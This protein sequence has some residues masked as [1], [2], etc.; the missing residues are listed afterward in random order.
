MK[1]KNITQ[2]IQRFNISLMRLF[3]LFGFVALTISCEM[4]DDIPPPSAYVA[5]EPVEGCVQ[6][7]GV[8]ELSEG[9]DFECLYPEFGTFGGTDAGTITV[10]PADNPFKE[11]INTS[12]KVIMVTQTAGV[13]GWAGIFFDVANKIDFSEEQTIKIKV[14]S[15]AAGQTI[16]LKLEDSADSSLSKEVSTTTT[17]AEGMGRAFIYIL[18][19]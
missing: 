2:I 7:E 19:R 9:I 11:G 13:E 16:L 14:Y 6:I 18:C 15:P 4:E 5:P 12:E 1:R 3:F 10:E 17:V 8:P